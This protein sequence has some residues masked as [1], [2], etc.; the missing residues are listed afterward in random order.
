[1]RGVALST[2]VSKITG[3]GFVVVLVGRVFPCSGKV[4]F[5][6]WVL[7]CDG[8]QLPSGVDS[9]S[10]VD[11]DRPG[12]DYSP[13]GFGMYDFFELGLVCEVVVSTFVHQPFVSRSCYLDSHR[14]ISFALRL[15]VS[16]K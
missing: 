14:L 3:G 7:G 10:L 13:R 12:G 8:F 16:V 11:L 9:L 5:C 15:E 1:M 6:F 4:V 2:T